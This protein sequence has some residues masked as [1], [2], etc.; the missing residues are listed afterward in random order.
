MIKMTKHNSYNS[1]ILILSS[2]LLL[3]LVLGSSGASST[4]LISTT[5]DGYAY[6]TNETPYKAYFKENIQWGDSIRYCMHSIIGDTC[7][8]YQPQDLAY[9]DSTGSQDYITS[10]QSSNIQISNNIVYYNNI[11][12]NIN[13]IYTNN[14]RGITEF[15]T[16]DSIPRLPAEYLNDNI[17]LSIGGYIKYDNRLRIESGGVIY[18]SSF[19]TYEDID[20]YYDDELVYSLNKPYVID[21]N[22]IRHYNVYYQVVFQNDEIFFYK[23]IPYSYLEEASY[24][25]IIDPSMTPGTHYLTINASETWNRPAYITDATIY[26]IGGG[27]AGGSIGASNNI[28]AGGGAGGQIAISN[29]TLTESSYTITIGAGG[30]PV[31]GHND[32]NPGG[33]TS[34][35]NLVIATGGPGGGGGADGAGGVG[36]AT[37]GTGTD[38]YKGGDGAAGNGGTSGGG[39]GGA[40]TTGA[41]GDA[42]GITGGSGTESYGGDGGTGATGNSAGNPGLQAGGGGAGARGRNNVG[43]TGGDGKLIIKYNVPSINIQLHT[44]ND[45]SFQEGI[46]LEFTGTDPDGLNLE[47]ELEINSIEDSTSSLFRSDSSTYFFNTINSIDSSPFISG[48]RILFTSSY[49]HGGNYTWRV[50]ARSIT[51]YTEWSD[52]SENRTFDLTVFQ[53]NITLLTPNNSIFENNAQLEF[54]GDT[55]ATSDLEY[56]LRIMRREVNDV[57]A[58]YDSTTSPDITSA[59]TNDEYYYAAEGAKIVAYYKENMS[60]AMESADFGTTSFIGAM[61]YHDGRIYTTSLDDSTVNRIRMLYASNLSI[62]T[63]ITGFT[64]AGFMH[65]EPEDG[66]YIVNRANAANN[67]RKYNLTT[68]ENIVNITY[69]VEVQSGLVPRTISML[70]EEEIFYATGSSGYIITYY[71][72][73]MSPTGWWFQPTP[74]NLFNIKVLD[75]NYYYITGF[76][77]INYLYKFSRLDNTLVDRGYDVVS[78]DTLYLHKNYVYALAYTSGDIQKFY[79]DNLTTRIQIINTNATQLDS[80]AFDGE[81]FY[82]SGNGGN[83]SRFSVESLT[84]TEYD[85]Y[86]NTSS[87]FENTINALD[88]HPFNKGETIRFTHSLAEEDDYT[89]KVRTKL[90][91]SEYWSVWSETRNFTFTMGEPSGIS[92][93]ISYP[94]SGC[95]YP[96]GDS[97]DDGNCDRAYF[98]STDLIGTANDGNISPEGQNSS[99]AW[100]RITNTGDVAFDIKVRYTTGDFPA[101]LILKTKTD[102]DPTGSTILTTTSQTILTNI[103]VSSTGDLWFWTDFVGRSGGTSYD[104]TVETIAE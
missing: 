66:L 5:Q 30:T 8:V 99:V 42:S 74:Y 1:R 43:G 27:G 26:A 72:N 84:E 58:Y 62:I 37:G 98:E 11:F 24:P 33:D 59:T 56:H 89:W 75:S 67:I 15:Y 20:F 7:F 65:A 4:K 23:K 103:A 73:N 93:S 88:T 78:T 50:R 19:T 48:D 60:K 9:T 96:K 46:S 90:D 79:Q 52:W 17:D 64:Y 45:T 36:V 97:T 39:G 94:V 25:I 40:G 49:F 69:G 31:S 101:S 21:S 91:G 35:G 102:N 28:A 71:K 81:H 41:G 61:I 54:Y 12:P 16:L 57:I 47:Y 29:L 104:T 76:W 6:V 95:S 2:V 51:G 70:P 10:I 44:E 92:F 38:F 82:I 100:M 3:L 87:G 32:G 68:L 34:F 83:I 53:K 80:R 85:F 86:S 13:L 22:G 55:D 14:V 77:P 63:T 18:D